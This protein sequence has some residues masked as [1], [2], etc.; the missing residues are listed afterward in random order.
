M[1]NEQTHPLH[2]TDKI[3]IDSLIA[4]EKPEDLDFIN[5]AR[6]INR[7]TNFPGEIEIK[8]D[9]KKILN[10]WQIDRKEL[11]FGTPK[12]PGGHAEYVKIPYADKNLIKIRPAIEERAV[13]LGGDYS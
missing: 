6:L 2:T 9:I 12:L 3:I 4:K 13:L 7:Y 10:F 5:L 8:N 1:S 11:F